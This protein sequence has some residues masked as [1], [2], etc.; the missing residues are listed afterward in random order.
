MSFY[1]KE[2]QEKRLLISD[3]GIDIL[4]DAFQEIEKLYNE[5]PS[6]LPS[7]SELE[8]MLQS[9]LAMQSE[10][11]LLE[12]QEVVDCKFKLKKRRKK[13]YKP[14]MVFAIKLQEIDKYAYGMLVKG[15]NV[16]RPY[17]EET[18]VEYFSLFTD[19]KLRISELKRYYTNQ[20]EVLFTAYT[21]WSG[22]MEGEWS[23]VGSVPETVF[24]PDVYKLPDFVSEYDGSYFLSRGNADIPL[25][26]CERI[27]E[28]EAKK[29]KNPSGII[30][31]YVIEDWLKE[32][33]TTL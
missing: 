14:G 5:G 2:K 9:A 18:Y 26:D 25:S 22:W 17:D 19:K 12:E 10:S 8:V 20:K 21:A 32:Q 7:I 13:A 29:I 28:K 31:Q 23:I 4:M 3:D 24:N 30:G 27:T 33:Y 11:F 16:T 1:E 6:R 15:Q